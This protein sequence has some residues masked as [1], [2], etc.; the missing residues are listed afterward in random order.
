MRVNLKIK[1][2]VS[3]VFVGH[4][5]TR[6][7]ILHLLGINHIFLDDG[8]LFLKIKGKGLVILTGCAHSGIINTIHYGQKLGE[9]EKIYALIGGFHLTQASS[10]RI[11]KTV[12]TLKE[13]EIDHLVPLHCTG[14]EAMASIWQALPRKVIIPSVGTRFE[15]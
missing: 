4:L 10:E 11:T 12:Q 13:K 6:E 3:K 9:T 15:L 1:D 2:T 14:F 5:L 7:E 8:A